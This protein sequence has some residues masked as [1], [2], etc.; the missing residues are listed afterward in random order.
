M[1]IDTLSTY[2]ATLNNVFT[3]KDNNTN[4]TKNNNNN[5]N[6]TTP[7]NIIN[8]F[9]FSIDNSDLPNITLNINTNTNNNNNNNNTNTNTNTK[10]NTH[11]S[12]KYL[13]MV[14]DLVDDTVMF[15]YKQIQTRFKETQQNQKLKCSECDKGFWYQASH[16][17]HEDEC[18]GNNFESHVF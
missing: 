5:T 9:N 8:N 17:K 3:D 10:F 12:N 7:P 11:F 2:V 1:Y 14:D 6:N 16:T 4:N 13:K 15:G 18:T